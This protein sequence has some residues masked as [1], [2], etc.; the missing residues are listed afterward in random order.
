[1]ECGRPPPRRIEAPRSAS[2]ARPGG[3]LSLAWSRIRPVFTLLGGAARNNDG[4]VGAYIPRGIGPAGT[5]PRSRQEVLMRPYADA[6]AGGER[7]HEYVWTSCGRELTV[8]RLALGNVRR[9]AGRVF[10]DLGPG[11]GYDGTGWAGLTVDEARQLA[12]A[13]L[14][15]AAAAERECG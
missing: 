15:Q 5:E 11:P 3:C 7:R 2:R 12:W 8:G 13:V 6:G 4:L 14:S 1:M 9:P 10:V